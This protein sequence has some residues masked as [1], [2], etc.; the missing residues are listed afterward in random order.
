MWSG[1]DSAESKKMAEKGDTSN[2]RK[3]KANT[4][5]MVHGCTNNGMRNHRTEECT[6][7]IACENCGYSN[8][9][10]Y[11]CKRESLWNFGAE[12]CAARLITRVSSIL[13]RSLIAKSIRRNQA[14]PYHYD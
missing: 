11:D 2:S 1:R 5:E 13:M 3:G 9:S 12:L 8:H 14:L 7:R 6:R 10:T 4:T